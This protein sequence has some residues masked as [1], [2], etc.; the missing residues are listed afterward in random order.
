MDADQVTA[1][2]NELVIIKTQML[3]MESRLQNQ[4]NLPGNPVLNPFA[5]EVPL[6]RNPRPGDI[7]KYDGKPSEWNS[8][9]LQATHFFQ[10]QQS[11]SN[12]ALKISYLITRF[13]GSILHYV[14][15]LS[16]NNT[17]EE[18]FKDLSKFKDILAEMFYDPNIRI[19]AENKLYTLVQK[20]SIPEHIKRFEMLCSEAGVIPADLVRTFLHSLKEEVHRK[21]AEV[22]ADTGN[23]A[24]ISDYAKIK[25]WLLGYHSRQNTKYSNFRTYP[26][27][28][29]GR[30][31]TDSSASSSGGVAPMDLS[32]IETVVLEKMDPE[33]RTLFINTCRAQGRCYG[34]GSKG[35]L[36]AECGMR[37]NK[38]TNDSYLFSTVYAGAPR[39]SF[40]M[41]IVIGGQTVSAL[42][43]TGAQGFLYISKG[44]TDRNSFRR[45]PLN[46]PLVLRGF[47]K[48]VVETTS[49]QT[50]VLT[51]HISGQL[52]NGRFT[53]GTQLPTEVIIGWSWLQANGAVIDC[54]RSSISFDKYTVGKGE[55]SELK[56]GT[57]S[58]KTAERT[59]VEKVVDVQ[60]L[61]VSEFIKEMHDSTQYGICTIQTDPPAP[62]NDAAKMILPTWLD[63]Y[64]DVFDS[65]GETKLPEYQDR[66]AMDIELLPGKEQSKGCLYRLSSK[67]ELALRREQV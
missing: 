25:H 19:E 50:E 5:T 31:R 4:S 14:E 46:N 32:V 38:G 21:L 18:M 29:S 16:H 10:L 44:C 2:R 45:E 52:F 42:V 26:G 34:C 41:P 49:E 51:F 48:R 22:A 47:D 33:A 12:D 54:A 56:S 63:S 60:I 62:A 67:E 53:V 23:N 66:F 30:T 40:M 37:I 57:K 35:H 15:G 8:F 58:P 65:A 55:Q 61:E 11:H 24:L 59:T 64:E 43:D 17:H 27:F 13:E 20:K 3:E 6:I 28:V 36:I 39:I 1:L 7:M 9:W